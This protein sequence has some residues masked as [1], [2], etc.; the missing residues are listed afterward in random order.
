MDEARLIDGTELKEALNMEAALGYIHT[1]QDVERV[2]DARPAA[3]LERWPNWQHGKPPERMSIY[4]RWKGTD[5]WRPGMFETISKDVLITFS[6]P[7]GKRYVTIGC[8][9][10]GKWPAGLRTNGRK[11]LAWAK[12]P[13]PYGGK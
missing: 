8:T 4:Y 13:E 10:D 9:I 5:K 12:L 6:V 3:G 7:G 11:V 2:I 1:L